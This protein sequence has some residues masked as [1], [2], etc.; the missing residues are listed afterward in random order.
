MQ[1]CNKLFWKKL[2]EHWIVVN[3]EYSCPYE[4][5]IY[6]DVIKDNSMS[7]VSPKLKLDLAQSLMESWVSKSYSY[8]NKYI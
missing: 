8:F 5:A 3:I 1:S 7:R 6:N 4:S 2:C